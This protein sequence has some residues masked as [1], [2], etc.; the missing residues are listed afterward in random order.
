MGILDGS[1]SRLSPNSLEVYYVGPN[2]VFLRTNDL[3][4]L[5]VLMM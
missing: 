3:Y 4:V 1:F 5:K 2:R